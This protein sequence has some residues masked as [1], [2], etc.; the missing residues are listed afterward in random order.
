MCDALAP[1]LPLHMQCAWDKCNL[2]AWYSFLIHVL[3]VFKN[4]KNTCNRGEVQNDHRKSDIRM[5]RANMS[6]RAA[7]KT[8]EHYP[9]DHLFYVDA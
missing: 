5:L 6:A 2:T 4:H 7:T 1:R 9:D 3:L 8:A